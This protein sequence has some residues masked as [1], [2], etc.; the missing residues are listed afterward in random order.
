MSPENFRIAAEKIRGITEYIYLHISGEPLLHPELEVILEICSELDFK[1][2]ITTNGTLLEK[3]KDILLNSPSLYKVSISLHSFE[4]N[5][6]DFSL[7][8]YISSACE[9]A[10]KCSKKNIICSLRLWN[11]NGLDSLNGDI[12]NILKKYFPEEWKENH[13]GFTLADK[14]YLERAEKFDWPDIDGKERNVHFC[15]GG[16]DQLGVL[17]DGTV[18]PCCLDSEGNIPLGNIFT[19]DINDIL[20]SER[21]KRFFDGFSQGKPSESLCKRCGYAEKMFTK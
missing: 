2:S 15:M 19:Q 12:L 8:S 5:K 20:S 11:T 7:E 9:F 13:R 16:R 17:A 14:V 1:V 4:A 18:V 10:L 21:Y 3:Q 6:V